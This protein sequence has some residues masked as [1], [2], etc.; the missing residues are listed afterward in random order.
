MKRHKRRVVN[1]ESPDIAKLFQ[2][3]LALHGQGKLGSAKQIYEQILK[4]QSNHFDALQ[5]LGT[6]YT[7]VKQYEVSLYFFDRAIQIAKTHAAVFN[8]RGIALKELTRFDDALT[9]YDEAIR[10]KP[11]YAEAL[12]NRANVLQELKRFDSAL[13]SYDA[14]LHIKPDYVEAL[15]NRGNVLQ[16]LKRFDDALISYEEVLRI[17]PNHVEALCNRGNAYQ[18][19]R[20]FDEALASYDE[21]LRI[22]PDY[23]EA[24]WNKSLLL[25][26]TG[27]YQEGWMLYET[28]S[29]KEDLKKNFPRYPQLAW[30]GNEDIRN[31]KIL[32]HSEQGLGDSLQF[33]RYLDQIHQLGAEIILEVPRT[34]VTLVNTIQTPI[35][36]IEKGSKL[37][38]FDAYCPLLSLPFVFKTTV[39]TIPS[40]VPYLSADKKKV[41]EWNN[42]LGVKT[43]KRIGLVWS[44][45]AVH[46]NDHNR[47][48]PLEVFTDLLKLPV[49]W[50]SLQ[51]EY[52]IEDKNFLDGHPEVRQHQEELG[53]FADTAALIECMDLV[54]SVDTSVAHLAGALGKTTWILLPFVPDFRWMLEREDCLW[55]PT[56][57]LLR[58]DEHRDWKKVIM[59]L[60]REL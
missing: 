39:D 30:R 5:L 20:R 6:I 47:S 37:P 45:S 54:I 40:V 9:S 36:I 43:R 27:N 42:R 44:G 53:D 56:A 12:Y 28:R 10:I 21:A 13:T 29:E 24:T 31:K 33:I 7:Q 3:G 50:H 38:E 48:I 22:K 46:K 4:I 18:E 55:Y 8:N 1:P 49:E 26:L 34:L 35:T 59:K 17:R 11:D 16:E 19:I 14:A 2:E 41:S 51:N 15:Y 52:R 57:K 58:Q 60:M 32:I 25:I 23:A